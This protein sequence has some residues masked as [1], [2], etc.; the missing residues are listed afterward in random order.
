MP[1]LTRMKYHKQVVRDSSRWDYLL[2]PNPY[3]YEIMHHA[4]RKIMRSY[5]RQAIRVMTD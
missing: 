4:F 3:S 1:G 5:Y 2:T